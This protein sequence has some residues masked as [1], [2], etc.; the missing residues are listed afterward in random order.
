VNEKDQLQARKELGI[1]RD[2]K[3]LLQELLKFKDQQMKERSPLK[4]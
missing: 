2:T 3:F 1:K 4:H